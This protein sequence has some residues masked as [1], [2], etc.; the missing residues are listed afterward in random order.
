MKGSNN[1]G[2]LHKIVCFHGLKP[3]CEMFQSD[4]DQMMPEGAV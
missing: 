4:P 1:L 2:H 3:R